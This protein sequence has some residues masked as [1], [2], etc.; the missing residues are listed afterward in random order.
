[1]SAT[2]RDSSLESDPD[3]KPWNTDEAD[4]SDQHGKPDFQA[5]LIVEDEVVLE[6]KAA[7]DIDAAHRAQCLNYLRASG[8]A[9]GLVI[10]FGLPRLD[11]QRVQ[12]FA[13]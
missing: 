6:L 8:L 4:E 2:G 10:N 1:V 7:R 11:V 13:S 5:D 3:S 9:L 12:Q